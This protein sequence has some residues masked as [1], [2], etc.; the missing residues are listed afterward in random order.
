MIGA[1]RSHRT[2]AYFIGT[3]RSH[4]T[5]THMIGTI[6]S[7]RPGTHMIRPIGRQRLRLRRPDIGHHHGRHDRQ[8]HA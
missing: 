5:G 6:R 1:I 4:G 3:V 2:R 8:K 7:H